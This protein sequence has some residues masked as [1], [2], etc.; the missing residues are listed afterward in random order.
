MA[1]FGREVPESMVRRDPRAPVRGGDRLAIA[2]VVLV[3]TVTMLG[4]PPAIAAPPS[5]DDFTAAEVLTGALPIS[6]GGTNVD[7]TKEA[8]EPSHVG[9]AGGASVWFS[10]TPTASA[11]V[12]IDMCGAD[13]DT[14]L[15]VYMG[16]TV[17]ALTEVRSNDDAGDCG[18]ASRVTFGADAGTTYLIAVD[19]FDGAQGTFPLNLTEVVRPANDDFADAQVLSGPLP[20]QVAG[21]NEGATSEP[22][23]PEHVLSDGRNS[24]WYEWTADRTGPITIET[25]DTVLGFFHAIA[26][27]TGTQVDALTKLQADDNQCSPFSRLTLDAVVGTTYHIAVLGYLPGAEGDLVLTIRTGVPANDN[28]AHAQ[29]VGG[30]LPIVTPG[31]SVDATN[32]VD[33][34]DKVLGG[35]Y[36]ETTIWYGWTPATTQRVAI[37]T[38]GSTYDTALGV[39]TGTTYDT[40]TPLRGN[41]DA[42]GLQSRV[43]LTATAATPYRIVI[44]G[45]SGA[46]GDTVLTI[47]EAEPGPGNDDFANA[48]TLF[49]RLPIVAFGTNDGAGD[50]P[51]EPEHEGEPGGASVWYRWTSQRTR[52]VV[53]DTCGSV[54]DTLLGVY[55][56]TALGT[57]TEVQGF[58]DECFGKSRLRFTAR[59]GRTY[60]IAVDGIGQSSGAFRLSIRPHRPP[61]NDEFTAAVE[62]GGS[63][64]IHAAGNNVDAT[65]EPGEPPDYVVP[66]LGHSVWYEWTP[67]VSGEVTVESCK[68]HEP[69]VVSVW[70]GAS[71]DGLTQ[72]P[73]QRFADCEIAPGS[74][75][76]VIEGAATSISF[77]AVAG[78]T[79]RIALD[80]LFA[81]LDKDNDNAV[82]EVRLTIRDTVHPPNDD[83]ADAQPLGPGIR[84]TA[85]GSNVDATREPL[86]PNHWNPFISSAT[87]VWYRWTAP[88]GG[89]F[90]AETCGSSF[91]SVVAVYTGDT[92][93]TLVD[94]DNPLQDIHD[95]S[96]GRNGRYPF[97]ATPGTTYRIAVS[98]IVVNQGVVRLT[99]RRASPPANDDLADARRIRGGGGE[100]TIGDNVDATFE[101]NETSE[102]DGSVW[103]RWVPNTTRDVVIDTCGTGFDT[104]LAVFTGS[105]Y[106]NL[107]EVA[108]NDDW[109]G[110]RSK[111]RFLAQAGTSY[112]IAV[113]GHFWY[114]GPIELAIRSPRPPANDDFADART[115]RRQ[116]TFVGSTTDATKQ[117]LEPN[118]A[119]IAGGAS[120][121]F[122]W[123]PS[124]STQV[125]IDTCDSAFSTV[126]GVYT[127]PAVDELQ[128]V[129]V[130]GDQAC[131]DQSMV[132]F[133]AVAGRTY[134]IAVDAA[135]YFLAF[136]PGIEGSIRLTLA[137]DNGTCA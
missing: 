33:E 76:S 58:R 68:S 112:L 18:V 135:D 85:Q 136:L 2:F 29:I 11:D 125:R 32:E 10:W 4:A 19:G 9:N 52:D 63:L 46:D 111:A 137:C 87:S 28:L 42:C 128:P 122:R 114:Q 118:H 47:R 27:Y 41:G 94:V 99:V 7:A 71:V 98:G 82:G 83:F 74:T 40:L 21:N 31:S 26:V 50:E 103:Y 12:E 97:N 69:T 48:R 34:I 126:L 106:S 131:G 101:A 22:G 51:G 67:A 20:I 88:T 81:V 123:K 36:L 8:G 117:A 79:Y 102:M 127:G 39:Y 60:R 13:Y 35:G 109:C 120:V 59:A 54:P 70:T 55:R 5:N 92:L 44:V 3:V 23:E 65:F 6:G 93:D 57:L 90:V 62:V 130:S 53:I 61:A 133:D 75:A 16:A 43:T 108:Y 37:E 56:G 129:A 105:T 89:D 14:L 113:G 121:W 134:R 15:A 64:P 25:C 132:V 72:A 66:G 116:G 119:G 100:P 95:N 45:G 80:G 77:P 84:V 104:A 115:L 24:V 49:G 78:T 91:D 1:S 96:C 107:T 30:P 17:D 38:C 110:R 124:L 86:E 73:G